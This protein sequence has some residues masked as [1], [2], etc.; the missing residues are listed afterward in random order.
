MF[1]I[2]PEHPIK[3]EISSWSDVSN[4]YEYIFDEALQINS[5]EHPVLLTE[6]SLTSSKN[7]EKLTEV[8]VIITLEYYFDFPKNQVTFYLHLSNL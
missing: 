7:R 1:F 6:L 3:Q 8:N 4:I 2:F 5:N